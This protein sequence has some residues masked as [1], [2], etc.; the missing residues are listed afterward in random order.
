MKISS[1]VGHTAELY[2]L[3]VH[4]GR[5][6]DSIIDQFFRSHKYLGSN[7]RRFIAEHV[8]A[9]IRYRSRL[10]E[11]VRR[12]SASLHPLQRV[13]A[14]QQRTMLHC[15]AAMVLFGGEHP[16]RL[17]ADYGETSAIGA[18]LDAILPALR[19]TITQPFVGEPTAHVPRI[20]WEHS[21]A[22]WMV[23][24]FVSRLGV[25]GAE[26]FCIALNKNAPITLRV[27]TIKTDVEHCIEALAKEG[28]AVERTKYSPFG[29][30]LA[31][32]TN[33]FALEVFRSGFFEMQDEG[34]QLLGLLVD[35]KPTSRVVDAC[36]GGGGKTLEL[37]ALM[38]NRGTIFALDINDYRLQGLRKRI[39]RS[40]VDTVRLRTVSGEE[41]P[42][43]LLGNADNVLIDAPCTGIGTIR[44]NPGMKWSVTPQ[45]VAEL[46]RKQ[47]GI[48]ERYAA[49]VKPNGRLIYATCTVFEEE[50]QQVVES[51]LEK[52]SNFQLMKPADILVRYGLDSLGNDSYFQLLPHIHGTDGFFAAVMKRIS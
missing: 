49:C 26:Q 16:G 22:E 47:S 24:K 6:A 3:I 12:C 8:Y 32:R 37:A 31:K 17:C 2:D 19:E 43:D 13:V 1:L 50:N 45:M 44:R 34:S 52:H 21:F 39:K 23:E 25:E 18:L 28:V 27:N 30:T 9:M 41:V 35:P 4:E 10:E 33:V 7:D 11:T 29:L 48:L 38:K 40:G 14:E 51:F 20:A 42:E 5:P 15:V 46:S 36:A